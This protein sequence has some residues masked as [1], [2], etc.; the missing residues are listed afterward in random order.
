MSSSLNLLDI[1]SSL[2]GIKMKFKWHLN[3]LVLLLIDVY[4]R[5]VTAIW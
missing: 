4:V 2:I 5:Y 3:L 1:T